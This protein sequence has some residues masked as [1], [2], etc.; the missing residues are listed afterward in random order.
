M[1]GKLHPDEIEDLLHR[2]HVGHLSCV[3]DGRP[4]VVPITYTYAG[5]CV[6]GHTLPGRKVTVLRARPQVCFE[7][8]EQSDQATWGSVVAE[9][10]YEELRDPL[11][12]RLALHL[13]AKAAPVVLPPTDAATDVVFRLRLTEKSGRFLAPEA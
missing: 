7:V 4:Y 12:R 11:E 8:A 5:G 1:I 6:Y 9:G 2:R 3:A 13:L 10:V